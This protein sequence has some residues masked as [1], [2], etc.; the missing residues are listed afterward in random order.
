[1]IL[2]LL[3]LALPLEHRVQ[4]E[5]QSDPFSVQYPTTARP[6]QI[7]RKFVKPAPGKTAH[8]G[9][10]IHAPNGSQIVAGAAGV[11]TR[12][13]TAEDGRGY[14]A[15]VTVKTHVNGIK[16]RVTYA[17]LKHISVTQGQT[18]NVGDLLGRSAGS[19][20]KLV[21]QASQ[22]GLSG[23]ALPNVLNPRAYL[24]LPKIRL[25]PTDNSLRLRAEPDLDAPILGYASQWTLLKTPELPYD[26]M[27]FAGKDDHWLRVQMGD[28]STAYAAAQYLKVVSKNDPREGIPGVPI[29]GMNLDVYHSRGIPAAEPLANL[30]WVRLNYNLSYNPDNGTYGNTDIV[31]TYNRYAPFIQRYR[32]GGKRIILTLTHQFYGEGA[33]YVWEQMNATQ[34]QQL[35]NR[36]AQLAGQ[37]AA[38]YAGQIYAYQVWNEQDTPPGEGHAAVPIPAADYAYMLS[39][40]ITAIGAADPQARIIT[41]GHISGPVSGPAYANAVLSA[42]PS[43]VRP[44]G[45]ALHPYGRG[46]AGSPF[47][48]FGTLDEEIQNWSG[49]MPDTP[50]WITEWGILDYQGND[51]IAAQV[52]DHANG[53]MDLIYRQYRG[54]V[55]AAVWYAWAD[56]MDNGYGLVTFTNQ[57]KQ[58]LYD[59]FLLWTFGQQASP[60]LTVNNATAA[61]LPPPPPHIRAAFFGTP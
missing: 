35:S 17:G 50:L 42:L 4:V 60:L 39:Q 45:M 14:G 13:V 29:A 32:D 5:A 49:V 15:Y 6:A 3:V 44:H 40:T 55:A 28:G 7:V 10:D 48:V 2:L 26:A 56:G 27:W 8:E 12:V 31:A 33:G 53:F 37:V 24:T 23:F 30:G 1:M 19:T 59:R 11:V 41:G 9:I 34:W 51:G 46:P 21:L 16:Y 52:A 38:Q 36:Y 54:M 58:P 18:V 20:V 22:G 57:P 25:R 47:N 43:G 61:W